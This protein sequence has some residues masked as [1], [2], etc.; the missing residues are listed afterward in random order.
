[1][2]ECCFFFFPFHF[3]VS[4]SRSFQLPFVLSCLYNQDEDI[5]GL[6]EYHG[7]LIKAFG[8]PYMVKEGPFLNAD[9]EYPTK[10][11]KLVHKKRS[12]RIVEDVS[13]SIHAASIPGVTIKK[14]QLRNAYSHE[15]KV[16]SAAE[17]VSSVQ[18]L[19]EEIPD[20]EAIFSPKDSKSA[21]GFKEMQGVQNSVKDYDMASNHQSP[22]SFPFHNIVPEPQ[23]TRM[24]SVKGTGSDFIVKSSPRRNSHL[25]QGSHTY[26]TSVQ[27]TLGLHNTSPINYSNVDGRPLEIIQKT[28]PPEFSLANSFS[29]PPPVAQCVSE[30]ESLI[31]QE[32]EDGIDE[33]RDSCFDEEIA[34]AKLKLFLRFSRLVPLHSF[35]DLAYEL[36]IYYPIYYYF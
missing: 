31:H 34:E 35:R 11:S 21:K 22:F 28:V 26:E 6:L 29:L 32:H 4:C 14:I 17:T 9:N 25:P 1:M 7:F 24:D 23:H 27:D 30:D 36:L 18:K 10:C 5:E 2:D 15:P 12:G 13:S 20:S 16:V 3:C 8:E 33:D 19:D